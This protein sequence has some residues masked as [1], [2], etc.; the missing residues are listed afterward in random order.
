M[1]APID[2]DAR[3]APSFEILHRTAA[4]ED[5]PPLPTGALLAGPRL[6]AKPEGVTFERP[7]WFAVPVCHGA[8]RVLRSTAAGAWEKLEN[9]HFVGGFAFFGVHHFCTLVPLTFQP[10]LAMMTRVA[11]T[12]FWN[13]TRGVVK[14]MVGHPPHCPGCRM[15]REDC[16][17][18]LH[19]DGFV[20]QSDDGHALFQYSDGRMLR[21]ACGEAED[22]GCEHQVR[23]CHFP[24]ITS[25]MRTRGTRDE[26][27]VMAVMPEGQGPKKIRL[28]ADR[29][30]AEEAPPPLETTE[31][32]LDRAG[33][34]PLV[35]KLQ[36]DGWKFRQES[37]ELTRWTNLAAFFREHNP[38]PGYTFTDCDKY[39]E[40]LLELEHSASSLTASPAGALEGG[41]GLADV[42]QRLRGAVDEALGADLRLG[43]GRKL[44]QIKVKEVIVRQPA[45]PSVG[46]PSASVSSASSP[47]AAPA[48]AAPE[49]AAAKAA[50]P[51]A[52]GGG[53]Q[54][55]QRMWR[56]RRCL[57]ALLGLAAACGIL[58]ARFSCR[59]PSCSPAYVCSGFGSAKFGRRDLPLCGWATLS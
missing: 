17:N 5:L 46:R 59:P 53:L 42:L 18:S 52:A 49:A 41:I 51:A 2:V 43:R 39:F 47:A 34:R 8:N 32:V 7:V 22:Q 58:R 26:D 21:L 3:H 44:G 1:L 25:G 24:E 28:R 10:D 20:R 35:L 6:R 36:C 29:G 55:R 31:L 12:A 11:V 38:N 4:P 27:V 14:A 19:G 56:R 16:W 37:G 30:P 40:A 33:G 50:T 9:V 15:G 45:W 48:P 54:R 57:G 13:P 23:V